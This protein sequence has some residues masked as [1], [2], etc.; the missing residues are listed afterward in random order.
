MRTRADHACWSI[1]T[2]VIMS[3]GFLGGSVVKNPPAVQETGSPSI[4]ELGRCPRE[5]SGTHSSILA[6]RISWTEEPGG[7]QSMMLQRVGYNLAT[8]TITVRSILEI[9][10]HCF[11][12]CSYSELGMCLSDVLRS[13]AL[14]GD[15]VSP[16]S[17]HLPRRAS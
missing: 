5:G 2:S 3:M 10:F 8:K 7:L 4:P 17:Q 16:D 13:P 9:G 6:W 14:T 1:I 11:E 12:R 15:A